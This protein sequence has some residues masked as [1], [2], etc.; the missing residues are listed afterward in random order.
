MRKIERR[1][2]SES[3]GTRSDN[4]DMPA[5]SVVVPTRNSSA[6][7][8]RLLRSLENQTVSDFEVIVVDNSS[9]D[10]TQQL[11]KD[12]GALVEQFGPERS[13]QRNRGAQLARAG[14]VLFIDSDMELTPEVVSMTT[15]ALPSADAACYREKPIPSSG[16]LARARGLERELYFHSLIYEAARG[17]TKGVF[18]RLGGYDTGLTGLEDMDLQARVVE[19][20][21]RLAWVTCPLL[22]HEEDVRTIDYLRKRGRYAQ[23]S[24]ARFKTLHPQYWNELASPLLRGKFVLHNLKGRQLGDWALVPGMA[25]SRILEFGVRLPAS[26]ARGTHYPGP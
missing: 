21:L 1:G 15:D 12:W 20:G 17:F 3:E 5:V 2:R 9:Q 8:P 14:R 23:L 16:Y 26:R 13:A 10:N 4:V 7:L 24:D 6:S 11:A 22:H 18:E 19:R 25:L